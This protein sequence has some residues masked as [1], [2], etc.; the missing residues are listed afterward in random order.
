VDTARSSC[1]AMPGH[2]TRWHRTRWHRTRWHRTRW[3][4]V[5]MSWHWHSTAP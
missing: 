1:P 4:R 5:R 3:H 2:R